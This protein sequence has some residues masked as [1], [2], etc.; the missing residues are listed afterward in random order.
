MRPSENGFDE[1][2]LFRGFIWPFTPGHRPQIGPY[3]LLT[4]PCV[5]CESLSVI[6]TE[7]NGACRATTRSESLSG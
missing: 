4:K 3:R 1:V 5:R 2:D 7:L 6:G